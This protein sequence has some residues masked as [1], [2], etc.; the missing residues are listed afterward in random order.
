M[1]RMS[2]TLDLDALPKTFSR[3]MRSRFSGTEAVTSQCERSVLVSS[4]NAPALMILDVY[5]GE[6][7]AETPFCFVA[8]CTVMLAPVRLHSSPDQ[9]SAFYSAASVLLLTALRGCAR[10]GDAGKVARASK[11]TYSFIKA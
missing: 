10:S 2:S 7:D 9:P 11:V 8:F 3:R 1:A 4:S 5:G 6:A